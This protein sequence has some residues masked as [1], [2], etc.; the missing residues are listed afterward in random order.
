ME[1]EKMED[2]YL[3]TGA[4][5]FCG[6][7]MVEL[8]VEK[9]YKVRATDLPNSN[10]GINYDVIKSLGVEFTPSD[11]TEKETLKKVLEGVTYVLHPAA[12]FDYIASWELLEKVNVHGTRNLCEAMVEV[13]T[14][15]RFINWS[16]AGVYGEPDPKLQPTKEDAPKGYNCLLY[17]KSK[18]EQEKVVVEFYEKFKLPFTTIRP[19]PIYGPRNFYGI[20]QIIFYIAKGQIPG[21][22]VTARGRTPFVNVKDVCNSALFLLNKDSAIGEVYNIVDDTVIT[23]YEFTHFVAPH[24]DATIINFYI[25]MRQ[26]AFWL[27]LAARWSYF[28]AKIRKTRPK[29]EK[30]SLNY[31]TRSYWFSNEKLKKL[32]YQFL[33]PDARAGLK[34]T[35]AWYRERGHLPPI[36]NDRF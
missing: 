8:L 31:I 34:E 29:I 3:V 36:E 24:V 4:C 15:K 21:I 10:R 27:G 33:Y 1:G 5:G 14:I 23:M 25:S 16:S 20:G 9:G 2:L 35:I 18:W 19:S 17:E 12:M 22:P 32:G 28:I 13:G 7:H 6:S 11:L 26:V 30:E